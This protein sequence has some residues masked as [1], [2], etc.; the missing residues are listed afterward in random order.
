[1]AAATPSHVSTPAPWTATRAALVV[2]IAS[3]CFAWSGPLARLASPAHPILIAAGRCALAAVLLFGF[4][5]RATVRAVATLPARTLLGA[6]LAGALLAA[7][8]GFFL[9]GL[10]ATSLPAAVTL[11]SLEPV[12]VVLTAWAAFGARPSVGESVGVGLATLGAVVLAQGAGGGE[13]RLVGDLLVLVAVALY[14][15]YLGVARGL[16]TK[17]QPAVYVTLV[18]A[19]AAALL[20]VTCVALQTPLALPRQSYLCI[21][22]LAIVPT[23]GGHTLVQWA[24][25][26]V[27]APVVALV[28]P[29]ETLGS[30]LIAATLLGERPSLVEA[31]GAGLA[32]LGVIVTLVTPRRAGG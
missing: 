2:G 25:A 21:A 5:P 18:Y 6:L 16:S 13:H 22:A 26:R 29:G 17:I 3:V 30:L 32:L 24:A 10:A 19:S 1:M 7:H 28:S 27:P 4:A 15:L 12:A 20:A 23:L 9:A 11:V 31:A 14:G 8:F